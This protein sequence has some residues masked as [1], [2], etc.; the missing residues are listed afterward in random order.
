[1]LIIIIIVYILV[2]KVRKEGFNAI[3]LIKP[4]FGIRTDTTKPRVV[5]NG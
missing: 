3:D 5:L 4:P 2:K 1:V